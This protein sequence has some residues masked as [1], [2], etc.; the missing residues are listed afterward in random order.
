[1]KRKLL[2]AAGLSAL[3]V[4][5]VA[6]GA[7]IP[8]IER[9][10][11]A[12]PAGKYILGG[13]KE[14]A[15]GDD[16]LDLTKA[17]R[18]KKDQYIISGG[19]S[20]ADRIVIDDDLEIDQGAKMLFRDDDGVR[21]T[22]DKGKNYYDGYPIVLVLDSTKKMGIRATDCCVTEAILG[23][24]WIHRW[25][26]ARK[27]LTGGKTERSAAALPNVFFDEEAAI[28]DGFEFPGDIPHDDAATEL[29]TV[30]ASLLPTF[31]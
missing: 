4:L 31:R 17:F 7:P 29:P 26:G 27:K 16:V 14:T 10:P 2:A 12:F 19:P 1:M 3:V 18:L 21:S 24:V 6:N 5:A 30:P 23:P 28:A 22:D 9:K 15:R 8:V 25:D 13:H 11:A 20:P